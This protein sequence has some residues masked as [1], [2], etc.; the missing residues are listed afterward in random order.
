MAAAGELLR[1]I[2]NGAIT[3]DHIIAE[4]GEIADGKI[5]GRTSQEEIT[6]YKSLG[7]A[8]QD[9]AAG[10]W[11]YEKSIRLKFGTDINMMDYSG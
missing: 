6:V 2:E 5:Q 7:V 1:A 11:L 3:K 9:L 10:H 4:I 8:A